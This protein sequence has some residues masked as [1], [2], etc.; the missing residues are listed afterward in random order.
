MMK[1]WNAVKVKLHFSAQ[2][3][4]RH[5]TEEGVLEFTEK[6]YIPAVRSY[7]LKL[8]LAGRLSILDDHCLVRLEFE[9]D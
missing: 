4:F 2:A 8:I 3:I 5:L 6:Q 9:L 7:C 1:C